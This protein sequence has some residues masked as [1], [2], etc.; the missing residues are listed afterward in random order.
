MQKIGFFA[1]L[2]TKKL[3]LWSELEKKIVDS[4]AFYEC[5]HKNAKILRAEVV[6]VSGPWR[7]AFLKFW[8]D[9]NSGVG[10]GE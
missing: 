10:A 3:T 6:A 7:V 9:R 4:Q 1:V 5:F 8:L 2:R